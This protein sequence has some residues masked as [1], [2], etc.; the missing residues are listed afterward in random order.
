M[1][2]SR[3]QVGA[4]MTRPVS[5]KAAPDDPARATG[6]FRVYSVCV[7][8]AGIIGRRSAVLVAAHVV[9]APTCCGWRRCW[10]S[11]SCW[12]SSSP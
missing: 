8:V 2:E 11:A 6:A 1:S 4:D 3:Q 9:P 5:P 12:P 7:L 10:P